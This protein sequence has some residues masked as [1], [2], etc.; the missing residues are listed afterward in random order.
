MKIFDECGICLD[1]FFKFEGSADGEITLDILNSLVQIEPM[2]YIGCGHIY[3]AFCLDDCVDKK[4]PLCR[5]PLTELGVTTRSIRL[6]DSLI[7]E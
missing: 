7:Q 2:S 1:I 4:C 5:I 3:H 6:L